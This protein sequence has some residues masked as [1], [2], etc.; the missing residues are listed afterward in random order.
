MVKF[1]KEAID[2]DM[3]IISNA[4]QSR[5]EL[6]TQELA[7]ISGFS[8][9]KVRRLLEKLVND[10]TIY[11][12]RTAERTVY[13][14]SKNSQ[15]MPSFNDGRKMLSLQELVT[16]LQKNPNFFDL[17]TY[18]SVIRKSIITLYAQPIYAVARSAIDE[19]KLEKWYEQLG[20]LAIRFKAAAAL[21]EDL[22]HRAFSDDVDVYRGWFDDPRYDAQLAHD[23]FVEHLSNE[24][25]TIVD[26]FNQLGLDAASTP[27]GEE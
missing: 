8:Y 7:A 24:A 5:G 1:S 19:P 21:C 23:L 12:S 26:C 22:Q 3:Q 2:A 15:V 27:V 11:V 16:H 9:W 17:E 20:K 6:N 14:A 4:L 18:S 25:G 10:G 13:F